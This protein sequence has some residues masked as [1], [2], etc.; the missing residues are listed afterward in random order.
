MVSTSYFKNKGK[1]VRK[2]NKTKKIYTKSFTTILKYK[3]VLK[4]LEFLNI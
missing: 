3:K 2:Q 4:F 1:R